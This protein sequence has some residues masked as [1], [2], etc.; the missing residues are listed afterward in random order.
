MTDRYTQTIGQGVGVFL[1]IARAASTFGV[2]TLL[3]GKINTHN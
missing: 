2:G 3:L 1:G